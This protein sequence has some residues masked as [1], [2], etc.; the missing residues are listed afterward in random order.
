GLP[1]TH[2]SIL[3]STLPRYRWSSCRRD[4]LSLMKGDLLFLG[5]S[6][7]VSGRYRSRSNVNL[8]PF[9]RRLADDDWW[10]TS[11]PCVF[12]EARR[13]QQG[14]A[15]DTAE[16]K[17]GKCPS[18]ECPCEQPDAERRERADEHNWAVQTE[19]RRCKPAA[20]RHAIRG[21]GSRS[22]RREDEAQAEYQD[23]GR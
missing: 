8:A 21:Y 18:Q 13:S 19:V 1:Q 4:P 11:S 22:E 9:R 23:D 7:F 16:H 14:E 17:R 15:E 12:R 6:P 10:E 5:C 20:P 2:G 3:L